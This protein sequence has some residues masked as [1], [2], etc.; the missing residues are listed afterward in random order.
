MPAAATRC[1]HCRSKLRPVLTPGEENF[2]AVVV[3]IIVIVVIISVIV[4]A[5]SH[6]GSSST[7]A[8]D[9][10]YV[11]DD[12][13]GG[14]SSD[15]AS[16]ASGGGTGALSALHAATDEISMAANGGD[17]A[18][19]ATGCDDLGAAVSQARAAGP[20]PDETVQSSWS[21]ALDEYDAAAGICS[22]DT[23]EAALTEA[24]AHIDAATAALSV[25]TSA[26][27]GS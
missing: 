1:G 4:G 26:I 2:K 21:D 18:G 11:A 12:T 7:V 10:S 22:T 3:G 15:L 14:A 20:I 24:T 9:S 13:G 8:D 23:S 5:V 16:W 17:T 6:H 27:G 19:I 25:A